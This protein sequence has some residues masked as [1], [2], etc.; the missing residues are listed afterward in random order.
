MTIIHLD[1][2]VFHV[3]FHSEW[4]PRQEARTSI[5]ARLSRLKGRQ[6]ESMAWSFV[7]DYM[8]NARR[9]IFPDVP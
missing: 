7:K 6:L 3:S 2:A 1:Q 8:S 5:R 9:A 4:K